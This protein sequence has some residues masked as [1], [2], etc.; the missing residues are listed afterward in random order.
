MTRNTITI[1]QEVSPFGRAFAGYL[2]GM[3]LFRNGTAFQAI[4]PSQD[5]D[6]VRRGW[7]AAN[8]AEASTTMPDDED[9]NTYQGV[10]YPSNFDRR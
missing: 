1:T 3:E 4:D 6:N 2:T 10:T 8:K 7:I 9:A 5:G